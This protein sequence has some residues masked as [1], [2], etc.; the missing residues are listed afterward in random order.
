METF[1]ILPKA[2]C[3]L[4]GSSESWQQD[5]EFIPTCELFL[6]ISTGIHDNRMCM[7]ICKSYIDY[8]LLS[9]SF[10]IDNIQI[11]L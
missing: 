2:E 10:N 7:K 5:S 3:E 4:E 6:Q 11:I 8:I 1:Y 9:K